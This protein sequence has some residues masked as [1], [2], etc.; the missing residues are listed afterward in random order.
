MTK[1]RIK[2]IQAQ[3]YSHMD[4]DGVDVGWT[5]VDMTDNHKTKLAARKAIKE[6][7]KK[8]HQTTKTRP[9]RIVTTVTSERIES[10]L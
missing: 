5:S 7:C 8:Y 10:I 1:S 6:H 3:Y 4:F 9:F 2:R